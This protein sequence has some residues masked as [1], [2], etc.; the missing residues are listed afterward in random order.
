MAFGKVIIGGNM[1]SVYFWLRRS[2]AVVS[3]FQCLLMK[4]PA[5]FL[6]ARRGF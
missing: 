6:R 3:A 1:W 5:R 4:E 2:R